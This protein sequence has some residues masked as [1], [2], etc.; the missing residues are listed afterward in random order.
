MRYSNKQTSRIPANQRETLAS[1]RGRIEYSNGIVSFIS[2]GEVAA[3]QIRYVGS[4]RANKLLGAGWKIKANRNTILIYNFNQAPMGRDLF[5]YVGELE[6]INCLASN[7]DGSSY[8]ASVK[9]MEGSAWPSSSDT[10][11][12]D[13]RKWEQIID[14]RVILKKVQKTRV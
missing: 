12:G 9:N 10:W 4:F 13:S 3:L 6:I 14:R 11:S 1:F 2:N 5:R 8:Y 7:W